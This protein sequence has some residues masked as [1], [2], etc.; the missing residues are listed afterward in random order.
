[1]HDGLEEPF[2]RPAVET[3][4][5]QWNCLHLTGGSLYVYRICQWDFATGTRRLVMQ[6]FK[7]VR[8]QDITPD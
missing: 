2:H 8:R 7:D 3:L 4:A 5:V 6:D 1:M